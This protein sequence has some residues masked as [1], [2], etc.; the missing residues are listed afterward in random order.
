M[1]TN[2]QFK[3]HAF[4]FNLDPPLSNHFNRAFFLDLAIV[5]F[6]GH[7]SLFEFLENLHSPVETESFVKL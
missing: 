1:T 4:V 6:I 5:V 2:G 7:T 3:R